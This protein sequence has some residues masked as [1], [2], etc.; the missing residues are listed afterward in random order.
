MACFFYLWAKKQDQCIQAIGNTPRVNT[1]MATCVLYCR[2]GARCISHYFN[3]GYGR[4]PFPGELDYLPVFFSI[5]QGGILMTMAIGIQWQERYASHAMPPQKAS[6]TSGSR[7]SQ[8][9]AVA[10]DEI[11][12]TESGGIADCYF[13]R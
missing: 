10:C 11:W 2:H 1:D 7:R 4:I 6:T 12:Y 8:L 5:W 13:Q 3:G 9:K